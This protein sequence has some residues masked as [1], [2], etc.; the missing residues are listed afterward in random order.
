[1]VENQNCLTVFSAN[2]T[3]SVLRQTKRYDLHIR[4]SLIPHKGHKNIRGQRKQRV[5][6][7]NG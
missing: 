7:V 4:H 2:L 3:Y 5:T 6:K 1:M